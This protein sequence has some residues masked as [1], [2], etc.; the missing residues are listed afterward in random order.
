MTV[1]LIVD[2]INSIFVERT[3]F[4]NPVEFDSAIDRKMPFRPVQV[5]VSYNQESRA[6]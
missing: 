2:V 1:V 3:K 5:R 4:R 6:S